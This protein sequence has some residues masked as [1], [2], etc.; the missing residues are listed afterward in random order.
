MD[1]FLERLLD[2]SP[3]VLALLGDN[4]FGAGAPAPVAARV[5][6]CMLTP[7]SLSEHRRTGLWWER[8]SVGTH[9]HATRRREGLWDEWLLAPEAFH[10]DQVLWKRRAPAL[11][12]L[13]RLGGARSTDVEEF[14]AAFV[15]LAGQAD[16]TRL[17][18][19]VSRLRGRFDETQRMRLERALGRLAFLLAAR[20]EPHF[21]GALA[22]RI[23]LPSFF[24]L[25]LLCHHVIAK[26]RADYERVLADPAIAVSIAPELTLESGLYYPALFWYETLRYHAWKLRLAH[27]S[28]GKD[29][30]KS[31]IHGVTDIYPLLLEHFESS[32]ERE[33]P[34]LRK[35]GSG[36]WRIEIESGG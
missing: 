21:C 13:S 11:R 1:R 6:L 4:P 10:W 20:L 23:A 14:W 27:K 26:G 30:V 24:H 7:V 34:R 18:D 29:A 2:G 31:P 36:D 15:P 35:A 25:G 8:R 32:H 16:W 17:P 22:P 28:W 3:D 12:A 19:V 9:M 5:G 33:M